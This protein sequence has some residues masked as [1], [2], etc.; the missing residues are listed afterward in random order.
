MEQGYAGYGCGQGAAGDSVSPPWLARSSPWC[1]TCSPSSWPSPSPTSSGGKSLSPPTGAYSNLQAVP[2]SQS[3]ATT[4]LSVSTP[5]Y[6]QNGG[7]GDASRPPLS[8]Q[9]VRKRQK[10]AWDKVASCSFTLQAGATVSYTEREGRVGA[11][12]QV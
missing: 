6:R 5:P 3:P 1:Q 8:P 11:D 4:P 2:H 9:Q 12:G 10:D 7:G